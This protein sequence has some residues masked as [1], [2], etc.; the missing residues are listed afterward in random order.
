MISTTGLIRL[1]ISS[2][3]N[4]RCP[5]TGGDLASCPGMRLQVHDRLVLTPGKTAD[6]FAVPGACGYTVDTEKHNDNKIVLSP[7]KQ[8]RQLA[9]ASVDNQGVFRSLRG[10]K[11][12]GVMRL[13]SGCPISVAV[14]AV[15][16]SDTA[17]DYRQRRLWGLES[18]ARDLS[19]G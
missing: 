12:G 5:V 16:G 4:S 10:C 1:K 14:R 8:C 7:G 6:S 13:E 17:R 15:G 3:G 2:F 9:E 19:C 11:G 18:T